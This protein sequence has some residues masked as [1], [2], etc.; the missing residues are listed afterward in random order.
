MSCS[1]SHAQ[2]PRRSCY[3]LRPHSWA[4]ASSSPAAERLNATIN[5][6]RKEE[7][8]VRSRANELEKL[9]VE[10]RHTIQQ[11][12]ERLKATEAQF[13]SKSLEVI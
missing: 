2:T 10:L 6:V 1:F 3:A 4:C 9:E 7:R 12:Q 11:L 13:H 5:D 8:R